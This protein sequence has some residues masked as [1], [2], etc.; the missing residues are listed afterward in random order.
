MADSKKDAKANPP[1]RKKSKN[2][3]ARQKAQAKSVP[4]SGTLQFQNILSRHIYADPSKITT[5]PF[6]DDF[7]EQFAKCSDTSNFQLTAAQVCKMKQHTT[8]L[9]AGD[10]DYPLRCIWVPPVQSTIDTPNGQM[11]YVDARGQF[12]A[13]TSATV[14]IRNETPVEVKVRGNTPKAPMYQQFDTVLRS[15]EF[16]RAIAPGSTIIHHVKWTNSKR[17]SP[18]YT[19]KVG[20][21]EENGVSLFDFYALMPDIDPEAN[22]PWNASTTVLDITIEVH[23]E[24]QPNI[25]QGATVTSTK[26]FFVMTLGNFYN[27]FYVENEVTGLFS[28]ASKRTL[29]SDGVFLVAKANINTAF[30]IDGKSWD[31]GEYYVIF[32]GQKDG[33]AQPRTVFLAGSL[34]GSVLQLPNPLV[35][36]V[37]GRSD[38]KPR[39]VATTLALNIGRNQVTIPDDV[40]GKGLTFAGDIWVVMSTA[41]E[42]VQEATFAGSTTGEPYQFIGSNLTVNYWP[43][44]SLTVRSNRL[45]AHTSHMREVGVSL[46]TVLLVLEAAYKI[47]SVVRTVASAK[48]LA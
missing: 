8:E 25:P 7:T 14:R 34:R 4:F 46:M 33:A 39:V 22:Q 43:T 37:T 32:Q 45:Q 10:S 16:K 21:S 44:W 1:K 23:Y 40:P 28:G 29:L 20:S 5:D 48:E 36:K 24:V 13:I 31:K 26:P 47:I 18:H 3:P 27:M 12:M 17:D 11:L 41:G 15:H 38:G 2:K 6:D 19:T 9:V 35:G 42:P 30:A